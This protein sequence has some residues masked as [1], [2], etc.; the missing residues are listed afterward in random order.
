[1]GHILMSDT[2]LPFSE[3]WNQM[4]ARHTRQEH[5]DDAPSF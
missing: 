2:P 5:G 4:S 1:M 3:G